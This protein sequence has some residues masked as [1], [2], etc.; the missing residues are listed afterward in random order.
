MNKITEWKTGQLDASQEYIIQMYNRLYDYFSNILLYANGYFEEV[1]LQI[2]AEAEILR[3][4]IDPA[5]EDLEDLREFLHDIEVKD[6]SI[7]DIIEDMYERGGDV[8]D[9]VIE[10]VEHAKPPAEDPCADMCDC[11]VNCDFNSCPDCSDSSDDSFCDC[12]VTLCIEG[13]TDEDRSDFTDKIF[14]SILPDCFTDTQK[15][16]VVNSE[17]ANLEK[18]AADAARNEQAAKD[19][20]AREQQKANELKDLADKRNE[21]AKEAGKKADDAMGDLRKDA[22]AGEFFVESGMGEFL[23]QFGEFADAM[24]G[25]LYGALA[26]AVANRW[27]GDGRNMSI[28]DRT[29]EQ[30]EKV[31]DARTAGRNAAADVLERGGTLEEAK[32]AYNKA[33]DDYWSS[34]SWSEGRTYGGRGK[35]NSSGQNANF[36]KNEYDDAVNRDMSKIEDA[37]NALQ[38]KADADRAA[39]TANQAANSQQNNANAAQQAANQAAQASQAAQNTLNEAR[40][41]AASKDDPDNRCDCY[42]PVTGC[43]EAYVGPECNTC[44]G[45]YDG[46]CPA[47]CYNPTSNDCNYSCDCSDSSCDSCSDSCDGCDTCP[48]CYTC[49]DACPDSTPCDGCSG[50]CYSCGDCSDSCVSGPCDCNCYTCSDCD[51]CDDCSDNPCQEDE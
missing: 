36:D 51:T 3:T 48:D 1:R 7:I 16:D 23:D 10:R 47:D 13:I 40:Q 41:E 37:F 38:D 12:Y 45:C 9:S 20:A 26:D 44:D 22:D 17:L 21:E 27:G 29:V 28:A 35:S 33:L 32:G 42:N 8:I 5:I 6:D 31:D 49:S 4:V 39:W 34:R 50:H 18:A 2:L 24:T 46:G 43:Q 30:S 11:D 14:D 15:S 25:G 19:A